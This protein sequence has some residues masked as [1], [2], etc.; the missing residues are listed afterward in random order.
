MIFVTVGIQL[1][2]DRLIIAVDKWA[3]RNTSVEVIAQCGK[4]KYEPRCMTVMHIIPPAEFRALVERADLVVA[5]AGMGSI[6]TAL[7][8]GKHIII[9][10]RRADMGEHRN[11]HQRAT[12]RYMASQNIVTVAEDETEL[13]NML[14]QPGWSAPKPRIAQSASGGLVERVRTFVDGL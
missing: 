8:L 11:D 3:E 6:I 10:P 4:S 7:E 2:F 9:M 1:P 13:L 14:N 12:A 5:H